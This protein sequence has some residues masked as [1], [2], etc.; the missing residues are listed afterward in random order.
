M[1]QNIKD[2]SLDQLKE[3]IDEIGQPKYR[4]DQVYE[5]LHTHNVSSYEE[6]TNVPKALRAALSEKYPMKAPILKEMRNSK[7]GSVKFLVEFPDGAIAETVA[8]VDAADGANDRVTICVSSQAGC[9]ME[10]IFCAT[11]LQ[12]FNRNLEADEIVAQVILAGKALNTRVSN[13]VFMGQ[14]EPFLNYDNVISALERLNKDKGLGIGARH[15][16]VSTAGIIDGIYDFSEEPEQFRLAISLHS[17]DQ[18]TRNALMPRLSG[19]PLHSLKKALTYYC[20]NKGR[21]VTIE[22]ML[23]DG[24]NDSD[25]QLDKLVEFCKGLNSHVNIL[26]FNQVKGADL[27]GSSRKRVQEWL[28]MLQ[29]KGITASLRRSKGKDVAGACGQL[30]GELIN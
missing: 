5:W 11:G 8:I 9:A 27:K 29:E 13:V 22:Y 26:E 20:E 28:E 12:G 7:D 15:I 2:L 30:A 6:M 16:T 3:L 21:R 10:C 18:A 17:A 25:D 4:A 19:Q 24:M 23:L 14:G 1:P